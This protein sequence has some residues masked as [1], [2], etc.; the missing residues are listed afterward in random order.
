MLSYFM[1]CLDIAS[2]CTNTPR[3][4]RITA[5][6]AVLPRHF[7]RMLHSCLV[8]SLQCCVSIFSRRIIERRNYNRT[9]VGYTPRARWNGFRNRKWSVH[10][11]TIDAS[12]FIKHHGLYSPERST[13]DCC[14]IR[15]MFWYLSHNC[16]CLWYSNVTKPSDAKISSVIAASTG[17]NAAVCNDT[18]SERP[19]SI[20][21]QSHRVL[22]ELYWIGPLMFPGLWR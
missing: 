5:G 17:K 21:W 18:H 8:N 2:K 15:S 1:G 3:P 7:Y 9:K 6:S 4:L 16:Y 19:N 13:T 14:H 10:T 20:E 22:H 11:Y 12:R